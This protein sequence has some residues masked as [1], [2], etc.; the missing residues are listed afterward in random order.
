[1][2]LSSYAIAESPAECLEVAWTGARRA[3]DRG[4][5]GWA[6]SAGGNASDAAFNLG[7]WDRVEAMAAELDVFEWVNAW[8][9]AVAAIVCQVRAYRGRG[10]EAQEMLDRFDAQFPDVMDP[11]VLVT[12]MN[13]RVHLAYARGD[14][15]EVQRL[16]REVGQMV[17]E[18]GVGQEQLVAGAVATERR[19]TTALAEILDV[20]RRAGQR[21]RLSRVEGDVLEGALQV[22]DG[23]LDGLARM[24]AGVTVYRAE[25]IRFWAGVTSRSRALLA[26]EADGAMA[27]ADEARQILSDLGA[28][29]LLRGLPAPS[30]AGQTTVPRG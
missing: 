16:N 10:A 2:N 30:L 8:D 15:D 12:A 9:F 5:K 29:T 18:L 21:G 4:Y 19:D 3:L 25:G 26:P 23:D 1:M 14:L 6:I 28:T 20:V 27:A 11:Q 17:L 24:D 7:E 13:V 22:I